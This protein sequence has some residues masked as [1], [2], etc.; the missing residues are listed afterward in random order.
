MES[1]IMLA[2]HLGDCL[3]IQR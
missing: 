1:M 2:E 3:W